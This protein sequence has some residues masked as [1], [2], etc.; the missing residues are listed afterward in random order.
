[1]TNAITYIIT[2]TLYLIR[3]FQSTFELDQENCYYLA[4]VY[5]VLVNNVTQRT[6]GQ[7]VRN[8]VFLVDQ[9]FAQLNYDELRNVK[10]HV[11]CACFDTQ[12]TDGPICQNI[13]VP[14]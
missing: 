3:Q 13:L 9:A 8:A 6:D 11:M 14:K 12:R 4:A 10:C 1:M 5:V 2:V 7:Y